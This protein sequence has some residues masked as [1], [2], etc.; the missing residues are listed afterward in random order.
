MQ[1]WRFVSLVIVGVTLF[2]M[3]A[4]AADAA[5]VGDCNDNGQVAINE[6]II[7]V[8]IALGTAPL[9]D[10]PAFDA[11]GGETVTIAELIGAVNSALN[12]CA[13]TPTP[14]EA[15]PTTAATETNTSAPASATPTATQAATATVTDTAT[16]LVTETSAPTSTAIA[17]AT[18]TTAATA[19]ATG[20][21]AATLTS[22]PTGIASPSA[23]DAA[24]PTPSFTPTPTT[25]MGPS[26]EC[27][28]GFLEPG[29]TCANCAAD[30][31][32][33]ACTPSASMASFA[34]HFTGVT[35]TI[36]TTVTA[37]IGYQSDLVSLPGSSNDLSVRQR[38]TYPAPPPFPQAPN[39]LNY[40]LRLVVG[41][42]A[43]IAS[44]LFA[45]LK[46]D[47]C[48]GG[49][50]PAPTDFACTVEACAGAG[51]AIEGCTCTVVLP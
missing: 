12:G 28:N 38:I 26:A 29:E 7:G 6:L 21:A 37:L 4:A 42:T 10:C 9:D 15:S 41:R 2:I 27:G 1:T 31:V 8:N 3:S 45:T 17:S 22:T 5:C 20:T 23:T 16:P 33:S 36:P 32:V 47:Q 35:G 49:A 43:G 25:T 40:A 50:V 44:G 46:F 13:A 19:T 14:V 48:Q 39:D 11:D 18:Q 34:V 51:G 30:C 24:S